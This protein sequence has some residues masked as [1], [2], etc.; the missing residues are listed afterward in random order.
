MGTCAIAVLL[1][2]LYPPQV[3]C[4]QF[5]SD[6]SWNA[7]RSGFEGQLAEQHAEADI[8]AF[9]ARVVAVLEKPYSHCRIDVPFEKFGKV[10]ACFVR[11]MS[12]RCNA[13]DD[14]LVQCAAAFVVKAPVDGCGHICFETKFRLLDYRPPPG[15]SACGRSQEH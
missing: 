4:N 1:Y 15:S 12:R 10:R 14:C 9:E 13:A 8:R 2:F 11:A 5:A 6:W 3:T 7:W